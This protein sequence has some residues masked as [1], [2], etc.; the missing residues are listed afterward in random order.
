MA[1]PAGKHVSAIDT[2][3]APPSW[4]SLMTGPAAYLETPGCVA[5]DFT[6]TWKHKASHIIKP[7]AKHLPAG[8]K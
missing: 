8:L 6:P 3:K 4:L 5:R 2:L 7:L 1:L